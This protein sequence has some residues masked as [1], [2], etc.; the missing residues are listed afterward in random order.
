[1]GAVVYET[2]GIFID[3][4][5]LRL[6]GSGHDRLTRTLPGWNE[7]RSEGFYLVA[8]DAV[9]GFFAINGGTLGPDIKNIYYFAPDRVDWESL[10]MGYSDFL[11]WACTGKL[12]GFYEWIRWSGWESDVRKLHGDRSFF[13]HP[14][15]FAKEGAGGIGRRRDIPVDESW[16]VQMDFRKQLGPAPSRSRKPTPSEK[17]HSRES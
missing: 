9:G 16:G 3:N 1:M 13:F 10:E 12:D 4:G 6:L 7:G 17:R 15:L 14:P 5:W 11:H 2:G 8:D